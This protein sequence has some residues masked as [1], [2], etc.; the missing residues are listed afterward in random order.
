LIVG[1]LI[2]RFVRLKRYRPQGSSLGET[3]ALLQQIKVAHARAVDVES[4]RRRSTRATL[5]R[6]GQQG[7]AAAAGYAGLPVGA[8]LGAAPAKRGAK[9]QQL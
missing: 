1:I 7:I 9:R 4:D 2:V 8:R 3:A 6:L 5:L